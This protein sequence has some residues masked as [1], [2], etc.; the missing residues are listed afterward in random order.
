M[1]Y[2]CRPQIRHAAP[3]L[4]AESTYV[5]SNIATV[6]QGWMIPWNVA[7]FRKRKM[8]LTHQRCIKNLCNGT[9]MHYDSKTST[10]PYVFLSHISN[11]CIVRNNQKK[12]GE[13]SVSSVILGNQLNLGYSDS[14]NNFTDKLGFHLSDGAYWSIE[15]EKHILSS[16]IWP[17]F[18]EGLSKVN[19]KTDLYSLQLAIERGMTDFA[20]WAERYPSPKGT[21]PNVNWSFPKSMKLLAYC[22]SISFICKT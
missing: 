4:H 14:Q 20:L 21:T 15:I 13:K 18:R 17:D 3:R 6:W 1:I 16:S 22:I 11:N 10:V 2:S 19:I 8:E 7:A 9:H 12:V 5:I